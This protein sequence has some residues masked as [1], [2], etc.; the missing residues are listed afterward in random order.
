MILSSI[1]AI[2][3]LAWATAAIE[4]R[5]LA[6]ESG[7]FPLQL[8]EAIDR[9]QVLFEQLA[10]PFELAIYQFNFS[11]SWLAAGRSSRRSLR[12]ELCKLLAQLGLLTRHAQSGAVRTVLRS[13]VNDV[14][15]FRLAFASLKVI[16][17]VQRVRTIAFACKSC[18]ARRK[19]V[20][21]F[22]DDRQICP[23]DR[24]VQA[25]DDVAALDAI[26]FA[27][28]QLADDSA[29]GVLHLLDI[30]IDNDRPGRDQ[31]AGEPVVPAQP[32]DGADENGKDRMPAKMLRRI[33]RRVEDGRVGMLKRSQLRERP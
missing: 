16:R 1:S 10:H 17:K 11:H 22:R 32:P 13:P 6:V 2:L 8:R 31:R 14:R 26:A 21:A 30:R 5:L 28:A 20:E 29:G 4:L 7:R 23:R 24:L 9:N 3:P 12:L 33:D 15:D 27:N 19:L 25:H 18:L